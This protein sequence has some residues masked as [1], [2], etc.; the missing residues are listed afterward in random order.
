MHGKG[1]NQV[2]GHETG[3]YPV[4]PNE[5]KSKLSGPS[6]GSRPLLTIENI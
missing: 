5:E 6:S 3:M 4:I 1:P 2:F